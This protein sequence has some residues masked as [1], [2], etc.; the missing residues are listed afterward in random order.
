MG[1]MK[2]KYVKGSTL[3]E[4]LTASVIFLIVFI[5]SFSILST[6]T[7]GGN[8]AAELIE[9]DV[10]AAALSH[11]WSDGRHPEGTH[12][13]THPWGN[14]TARLEP[15]ADYPDLQQLSITVVFTRN[16]K[17]IVYEQVVEKVR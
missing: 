8:D 5:C 3:I 1:K 2:I 15:Y 11:E 9:A 13:E 7:P 14:V 12:T 10:R 17:R 6:L 16:K 4:V